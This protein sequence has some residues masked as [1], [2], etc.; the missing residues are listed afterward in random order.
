M[1]K[2]PTKEEAL[3][4]AMALISKLRRGE[5]IWNEFRQKILSNNSILT[6]EDV[7]PFLDFIA[8]ER[9]AYDHMMSVVQKRMTP[10][11]ENPAGS[12]PNAKSLTGERLMERVRSLF[13][14]LSNHTINGVSFEEVE[15]VALQE[16]LDI[17]KV[18]A[19]LVKMLKE[20][21]LY[22]P[23]ARSGLFRLVEG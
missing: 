6:I 3:Q 4:E 22:E 1:P 17:E 11:D 18:H 20:N 19:I 5:K 9:K 23:L 12:T 14:E 10:D 21:E 13:R 8:S 16:K 15:T 7:Q 2:K